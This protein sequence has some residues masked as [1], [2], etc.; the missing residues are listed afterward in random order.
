MN[1]PLRLIPRVRWR[2]VLLLQGAPL[3]GAAFAA[4]KMD[5]HKLPA[6]ALLAVADVLL[7]AHV[8]TLNDWSDHRAARDAKGLLRLSLAMLAAALALFAPLGATVWLL[9]AAIAFVGYLYSHSHVNTKE[10]PLLSSASHIAGGVLHFLLGWALFA[11]IGPR[12]LLLASFFALVFTAG[13]ATQEVQD[14]DDDRRRGIRTNAVVFGK[15]RVFIAAC[16]GFAL[17]YGDVLWLSLS[18]VMPAV[19]AWLPPVLLPLQIYWSL[20]ALRNG[21]DRESVRRV[22]NR[23]RA[24]FAVIGAAM[25]LTLFK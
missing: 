9:A 24:L 25:V 18:G 10:A 19:L 12:A 13:H 8:W 4:G 16:A 15:K 11:R 7:V 5:A 3:L 14:Y 23:Y 21:L 2:E 22:R 1:S 17:A 20:D 6:L